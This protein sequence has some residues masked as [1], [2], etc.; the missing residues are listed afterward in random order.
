M[1]DC[2]LYIVLDGIPPGIEC[3]VFYAGAVVCG[4]VIVRVQRPIKYE[5]LTLE[6]AWYCKAAWELGAPAIS[7][8]LYRG[9]WE[10]HGEY[11]YRFRFVCPSEPLSYSGKN[12]TLSWRLN[13]KIDNKR[14]GLFDET[15]R[16]ADI[17]LP[18]YRDL[19]IVAVPG[20]TMEIRGGGEN[21]F[22]NP[23][24]DR[25][26]FAFLLWLI[27]AFLPATVSAASL[28]LRSLNLP[29]RPPFPWLDDSGLVL[30]TAVHCILIWRYIRKAGRSALNLEAVHCWVEATSC[31]SVAV[32]F[33]IAALR[34]ITELSVCLAADEYLVP[35]DVDRGFRGSARVFYRS[36]DV[37]VN[38]KRASGR[39]ELQLPDPSTLQA[40]SFSTDCLDVQWSAGVCF[41]LRRG[42]FHEHAVAI[43]VNPVMPAP[44]QEGRS[45]ATHQR[46]Q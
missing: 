41:R 15:M 42:G 19:H 39:V 26:R 31:D 17:A 11:S 36:Q 24:R 43:D 32:E 9:G 13:A 40:W 25:I 6:L 7:L 10:D 44:N 5:I 2:I 1:P 29:V 27:I 20:A 21:N 34:E 30:W 3:P 37:A 23:K 38:G 33:E 35:S 45:D 14:S 8:I 18:T 16:M 22:F 46:N 28:V 4:T 12:A